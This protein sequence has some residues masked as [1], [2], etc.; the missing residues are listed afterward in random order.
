MTRFLPILIG[1][2]TLVAAGI[3]VLCGIGTAHNQIVQNTKLLLK[4][5]ASGLS[6][7]VESLRQH[8]AEAAA[9]L[10]MSKGLPS[11]LKAFKTAAASMANAPKFNERVKAR[12]NALREKPWSHVTR[13]QTKWSSPDTRVAFVDAGGVVLLSNSRRISVATDLVDSKKPKLDKEKS[14]DTSSKDPLS[15]KS[16]GLSNEIRTLIQAALKGQGGSIGIAERGSIFWMAAAPILQENRLMGAVVTESKLK[17]LPPVPFGSACLLAD[18]IVGYGTAPEGFVLGLAGDMEEPHVVAKK[19][20]R[21]SFLGLGTIPFGPLFVDS[22]TVGIWGV[23]FEIE[24][25]PKAFG[26]ALTDM[27]PVSGDIASTQIWAIML[28]LGVAIVYTVVILLCSRKLRQGVEQVS[29]FLSRHHLGIGTEK[30][31]VER[32]VPSDLVRLARLINTIV[33][34]SRDVSAAGR[35]AKSPTLDEVLH[36]QRASKE[37]D[38]P[39]FQLNGLAAAPAEQATPFGDTPFAGSSDSAPDNALDAN[40]G[41]E[42]MGD[43]AQA[44]VGSAENEEA[45]QEPKPDSLPD[46]PDAMSALNQLAEQF[47]TALSWDKKEEQEVQT[48]GPAEPS[49]AV[50]PEAMPESTTEP[51]NKTPFDD[52]FDP[53]KTEEAASVLQDSNETPSTSVAPDG[54]AAMELQADDLP[55]TLAADDTI[56]GADSDGAG[57]PDAADSKQAAF[58]AVYDKFVSLRQQCGESTSELSFEKFSAKLENT[59]AAV[60]AKHQCQ[61]VQFEVF[62][63]NGKAALK[64]VPVR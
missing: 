48:E 44:V 29:D 22:D 23:R 40:D 51:S 42:S 50:E 18:G 53:A 61:D 8:E 5:H 52:L 6:S 32:S 59:R 31:L 12:L 26:V 20:P 25:T 17:D 41:Y 7:A 39:E 37:P 47:P 11:D 24:Q 57:D 56:L 28:L 27:T 60:L 46:V 9:H 38:I 35:S 21:T 55:D 3:G 54:Q 49:L 36:A 64:A 16:A 63:K 34:G 19:R 45:T 2:I 14:P 43:I 33:S 4:Q 15:D 1:S 58:H 13:W 30:Q 62:E 10:A